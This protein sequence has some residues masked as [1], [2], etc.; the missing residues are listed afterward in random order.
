[1]RRRL[2]L[3]TLATTS[4]VVI[5]LLVPLALL[6]RRQASEDARLEAEREARSVAGLTALALTVTGGADSVEPAVGPLA[7]GLL[8][9]LPD[10]TVLGQQREAQGGLIEEARARQA[11]ITRAVEGGWEIALPVVG[12]DGVVVVDAFVSDAELT[13]GVLRA[14]LLLALLGV[15]LVGTAVWLA[16]RLGRRLVQPVDELASAA[17]RLGTG[18]LDVRVEVTEPEELRDVGRAFNEL[19]GRLEVLLAEERESVA[20]LSHGLRTPLTSLRLQVEK[21]P[22][23]EQRGEL[24]NQVDRLEQSIDR[25]IVEAR[26]RSSQAS[27]FSVLDDV[28]SD[29]LAFWGV[30]AD[31]Q[32][33][34][35]ELDLD[36]EHASVELPTKTVQSIVDVL[37]GNVFSHTP[38]G[39]PF[40]VR[41][42]V[43][44]AQALVEV[45]DR[46]PGFGGLMPVRGLSRGGST[47][48]GLDIARK[49]AES[50]GGTLEVDDRPSGGAV[51]R[52]SVRLVT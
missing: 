5:S 8:V 18:D 11:T 14:W 42:R 16:D 32:E 46:G 34:E 38:P 35:V 6:V 23:T 9:I 31:E 4:L 47:G 43:E 51:V 12:R 13:A 10:G 39:T 49:A 24:I 45:L 41:T 25:L 28:V 44:G 29:R 30:L 3:L 37:V 22:D 52:L 15:V 1:M 17:R 40:E 2:A 48:L 36:A 21:V 26:S 50:T 33:R 20:D 19:A 7:D 27:G